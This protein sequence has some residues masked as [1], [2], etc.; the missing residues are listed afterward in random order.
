MLMFSLLLDSD[1]AYRHRWSERFIHILVDE[2]QDVNDLQ[3]RVIDQLSSFHGKVFAI[4]DHA[5][6]IY[7]F[8]GANVDHFRGFSTRFKDAQV[9]QLTTNFRS[10]SNIVKGAELLLKDEAI[11]SDRDVVPVR[12]DGLPIYLVG[13][14]NKEVEATFIAAEVSRLLNE[15]LSPSEISVLVRLKSQ[16]S[17]LETAFREREIPVRI[18]AGRRLC[19]RPHVKSALGL[20]R[21]AFDPNDEDALYNV[22]V[23]TNGFGSVLAKG[24]AAVFGRNDAGA[25]TPHQLRK[26]EWFK[27][28]VLDPFNTK[29]ASA[30]LLWRVWCAQQAIDPMQ[31]VDPV[32]A[33]LEQLG[34]LWMQYESYGSLHNALLLGVGTEDGDSGL[35]SS[36]TLMSIHQSK[37]LEWNT[38][39]VPGLNEGTLPIFGSKD[40]QEM[41]SEERRLLYVACTRARERLYLSCQATTDVEFSQ[42]NGYQSRFLRHAFYRG[43]HLFHGIWVGE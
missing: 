40:A 5:Q 28:N 8:R 33:D 35:R 4:G 6:A 34:A 41:L 7:G 21:L 23:Q 19:D 26:M 24:V 3:A 25:L 30:H 20:I 39:F 43:P 14:P 37:G 17:V 36:V 13:S 2:Y 9:H 15:G 38:V 12:E 1:E 29:P 32:T 16:A 11:Y 22:A 42:F 10:T 18:K 31:R 27:A